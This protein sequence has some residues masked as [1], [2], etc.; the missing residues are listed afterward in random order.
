VDKQQIVITGLRNNGC[1]EVPTRSKLC[2]CMK[3]DQPEFKHP[4]FWFVNKNGTTW[5]NNE[6]RIGNAEYWPQAGKTLL[7]RAKTQGY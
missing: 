4:E 3:Y 6:N 7:N 1:W 2:R 5:V